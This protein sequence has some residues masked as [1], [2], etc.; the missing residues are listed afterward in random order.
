M[1]DEDEDEDEYIVPVDPN[2]DAQC[3]SCQ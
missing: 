1:D 3:E 2:D